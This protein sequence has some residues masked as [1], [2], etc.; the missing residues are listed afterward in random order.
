MTEKVYVEILQS[1]YHIIEED[2]LVAGDK[3][4]SERELSERLKVGRSS[5]REALRSLE[6]LGLIETR[7]GEGT[8][9]KKFGEH[10]FIQLLGMFIL[11][12]KKANA[13]LVETKQLIEQLGLTL[14]CE[15]RTKEQ[16]N[17][18]K[19]MIDQHSIDYETF[20]Q[21]VFQVGN[22]YLLERI[23]RVLSDFF[24]LHHDTRLFPVA[25]YQQMHIVLEK[26]Q[27]PDALKL[28]TEN[29]ATPLYRLPK[30]GTPFA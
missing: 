28:L 10:Q 16:L 27:L 21:W 1:I 25:F 11:Q 4:P 6:F 9:L 13:D 18:L 7:R 22:N 17:E 15:R 29:T 12:E 2:G 26:Q 8:Y 20:F 3:I 5:V 24:Q 19:A 30:E 14:A 23:W